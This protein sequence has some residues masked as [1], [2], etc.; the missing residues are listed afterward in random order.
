MPKQITRKGPQHADRLIKNDVQWLENH[1]FVVRAVTLSRD[2]DTTAANILQAASLVWFAGGNTFELMSACLGAP[3]AMDVLRQRVTVGSVCLMS[4]S[5]GSIVLGTS[6][7]ASRD[8][9]RHGLT[10]RSAGLAI[11]PFVV[12]PLLMSGS[13]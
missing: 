11:V 9:P 4:N 2:G 10:R 8:A 3:M 6:L 5:A 12:I 13:K 7:A 1:G